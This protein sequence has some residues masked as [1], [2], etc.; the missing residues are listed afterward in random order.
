MHQR[1][2]TSHAIS[3]LSEAAGG[4]RTKTNLGKLWWIG[5]LMV[6]PRSAAFNSISGTTLAPV[7]RYRSQ[8]SIEATPLHVTLG[9]HALVLYP[10]G[11]I[12]AVGAASHVL[13]VQIVSHLLVLQAT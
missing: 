2:H 12:L 9:A 1:F 5:L 6:P 11:H 13:A 7:G 4:P 3:G 8:R 10:G